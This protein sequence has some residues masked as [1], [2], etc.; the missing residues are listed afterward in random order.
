MGE[1]A[2]RRHARPGTNDPQ[3]EVNKYLVVD[4]NTRE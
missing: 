2:Q 4:R 3:P 1:D